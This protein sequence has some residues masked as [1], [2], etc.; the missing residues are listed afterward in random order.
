MKENYN[1]D[2]GNPDHGNYNIYTKKLS[3]L[4]DFCDGEKVTNIKIIC[5]Q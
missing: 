1:E 4:E 5:A 2:I 3:Q